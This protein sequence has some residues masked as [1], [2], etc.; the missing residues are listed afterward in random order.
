MDKK[1]QDNLEKLKKL[2]KSVMD[3]IDEIEGINSNF[4][5]SMARNCWDELENW[6]IKHQQDEFSKARIIDH[7]D[8]SINDSLSDIL[9]KAQNIPT[10]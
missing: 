6:I 2:T 8:S 1:F 3:F 10:C 7:I 4:E 5:I 9:K